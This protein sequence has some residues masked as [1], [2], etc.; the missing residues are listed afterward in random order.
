MT[1]EFSVHVDSVGR[2]ESMIAEGSRVEAISLLTTSGVEAD[3]AQRFADALGAK[4]GA[5]TLSIFHR[6]AP[7][8]LE[9]GVIAWLDSGTAGLWLTEPSEPEAER[10]VH[11]R[12]VGPGELRRAIA[13]CLP[14]S[15]LS[16]VEG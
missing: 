2:C 15:F 6:P 12:S 5:L 10:Q 11:C 4:R 13:D 7:A 14:P 3:T 9:G 16:L 1:D 8:K